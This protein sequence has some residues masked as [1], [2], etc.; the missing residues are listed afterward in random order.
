MSKVPTRKARLA[1]AA[2]HAELWNAGMKDEWVASWRTI[3]PG[4]V[5]MFDPVGTEEK[6]G[7]ET[8]TSRAFDT[9]QSILK[10]KMLTVQVNGDEMAWVCENFFGT[11]PNV[12]SAY[13]IETFAWDH[14]G[15]LL[16]KTYY[17]MPEHI[18]AD[19]DPYAHLLGP[20]QDQSSG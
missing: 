3:C 19:E 14:D 2:K 17:P 13:S 4:E 12:Q 10:I 8:A 1:H 7:F 9:F 16:I 20:Q 15:N 11:E 6:R 18:C 5:R